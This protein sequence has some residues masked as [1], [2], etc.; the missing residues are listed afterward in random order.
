MKCPVCSNELQWLFTSTYCPT[1]EGRETLKSPLP[2]GEIVYSYNLQDLL[3]RGD[4]IPLRGRKVHLN[5]WTW[6]EF[7]IGPGNDWIDIESATDPNAR[8]G[9]AIGNIEF[10]LHPNLYNG[11]IRIEWERS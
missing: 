4:L 2:V 11:E 1:C 10:F 5:K 9:S 6:D 7:L 3:A 8:V